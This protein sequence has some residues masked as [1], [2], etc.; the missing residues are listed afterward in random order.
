MSSQIISNVAQQLA[1]SVN[2]WHR[3]WSGTSPPV[4]NLVTL[5]TMKYNLCFGI[6]QGNEGILDTV[7]FIIGIVYCIICTSA[8]LA[9]FRIIVMCS[10]LIMCDW[11]WM[12]ISC[13]MCAGQNLEA[14]RSVPEIGCRTGFVLRAQSNGTQLAL[15]ARQ[16]S[17]PFT[18][19]YIASA[20]GTPPGRLRNC[21]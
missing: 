13:L 16:T 9:L 2:Y 12:S 7:G 1:I 6:E 11:L 10:P 18:V 5:V 20:I 19:I 21:R 17:C 4:H 8:I 14:V 3:R 15:V